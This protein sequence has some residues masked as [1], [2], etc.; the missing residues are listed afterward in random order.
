MAQW[1]NRARTDGGQSIQIKWRMEG[2]WQSETFTNARAASEFRAA[3]EAC[4]H[5]WP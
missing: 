1:V 3:V 4:G 5:R 2:R